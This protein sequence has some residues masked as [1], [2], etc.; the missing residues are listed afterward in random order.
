MPTRILVAD[1]E[2]ISREGIKSL[3][4]LNGFEICGEAAE[5]RA[6]VKLANKLLPDAVVAT[7]GLPVLNGIETARQIRRERPRA[8]IVM[9]SSDADSHFVFEAFAAGV[10]GYLL[11]TAGF[12]EL[13][14]SLRAV[15]AGQMYVSPAVAEVVVRKSLAGSGSKRESQQNEISSREREVLQLLAEGRSTKEIATTLYISVKTVETHRK[16]IMQKLEVH[17]I[18]GLTKYAVREGISPL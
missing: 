7:L 13:V 18:A 12:D 17:S 6:A 5:G 16:Q 4:Q 8:K 1:S 3:L 11:K 14:A 15:L 2:T 10:S 9:I